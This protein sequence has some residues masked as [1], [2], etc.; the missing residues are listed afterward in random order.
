MIGKIFALAL[1][2]FSTTAVANDFQQSDIRDLQFLAR[3]VAIDI[4][5]NYRHLPDYEVRDLE[6]ELGRAELTL[7]YAL[8][9]PRRPSFEANRT[10]RNII[11]MLDRARPFELNPRDEDDVRDSLY[12]AQDIVRGRSQP[13]P[14]PHPPFGNPCQGVING[15][16]GYKGGRAMTI[17]IS[18]Q[19]G[20]Q[21][22][23]TVSQQSK[24]S[25]KQFIH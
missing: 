15:T 10:I 21:V 11:S 23:V 16:W 6:D 22:S 1:L 19:S 17:T 14:P 3:D 5:R 8:R 24:R 25:M 12:R 2:C 20:D 7:Q 4:Q 18:Q 9:Y 13:L